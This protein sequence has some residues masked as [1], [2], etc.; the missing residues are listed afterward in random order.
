MTPL[1][2]PIGCDH[3]NVSLQATATASSEWNGRRIPFF[4][5][6]RVLLSR[7]T[8]ILEKDLNCKVSLFIGIAFYLG[9]V[10]IDL[11]QR[12]SGWFP[13]NINDG[14]WTINVAAPRGLVSGQKRP[15]DN[16]V[17]NLDKRPTRNVNYPNMKPHRNNNVERL[18]VLDGK[19][20]YLRLQALN[21]VIMKRLHI[22]MINFSSW[23]LITTVY[24][25]VKWPLPPAHEVARGSNIAIDQGAQ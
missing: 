8:N 7:I 18:Q 11:V 24:S 1:P 13:G 6:Y 9:N 10:L 4:S 16:G 3:P 12:Q 22:W 19:H 23:P 21:I 15:L 14:E 2:R 25:F 17:D 20:N 5:T